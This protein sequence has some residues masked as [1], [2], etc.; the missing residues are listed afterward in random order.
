MISLVLFSILDGDPER[1]RE[2]EK[3]KEEEGGREEEGE[4]EG[5]REK[6]EKRKESHVA[7]GNACL[8]RF[9][10]NQILRLTGFLSL[11]SFLVSF[12]YLC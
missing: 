11:L 5:G 3:G 2:R 12:L 9:A 1:E 4:R 10:D 7:E 6:E 8:P